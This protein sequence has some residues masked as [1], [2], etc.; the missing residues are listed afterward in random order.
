MFAGCQSGQ[1]ANCCLAAARLLECCQ[2]AGTLLLNGFYF[3]LLF[4]SWGF[5]SYFLTSSASTDGNAQS[6]KRTGRTVWPRVGSPI[7]HAAGGKMQWQGDV[8]QDGAEGVEEP[9]LL[10]PV[11]AKVEVG[12]KA[13]E[14][15]DNR[16]AELRGN[17]GVTKDVAEAQPDQASPHVATVNPSC[18]TR[19]AGTSVPN[20]HLAECAAG[21]QRRH[22]A[23]IDAMV[24]QATPAVSGAA[25]CKGGLARLAGLPGKKLPLPVQRTAA[26]QRCISNPVEWCNTGPIASWPAGPPSHFLWHMATLQQDPLQRPGLE[27]LVGLGSSREF[28]LQK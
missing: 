20:L 2:A 27:C 17:P 25:S 28:P 12:G 21:P 9:Y 5:Q 1:H 26:C 24:L 8:V 3:A 4:G 10:K 15:Q 6:R 13:H 18:S 14:A 23:L 11:I 16:A 19:A 7:L 22:I